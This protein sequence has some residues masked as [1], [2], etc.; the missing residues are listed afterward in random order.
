VTVRD[1][2]SRPPVCIPADRPLN[3]AVDEYF[4]HHHH[5]AFPVVTDEGEFRGLLR[6]EFL[7]SVPR[8]KWPY[9]SAGDLAAE[10]ATG[11]LFI[12]VGATA[13]R[14]MRSLLVPETGRLAVVD[15][16]KVIGVVTRHD[17]L[18]FIKIHTELEE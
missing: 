12:D 16:G 11:S 2:M 4:L 7:K 18:Q 13:A 6:L 9:L 5:V 17:I 10:K 1:L 14:A 8:E 3:L 15:N